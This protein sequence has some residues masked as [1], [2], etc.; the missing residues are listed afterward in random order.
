LEDIIEKLLGE[1]LRVNSKEHPVLIGE[2]AI[3]SREY[4]IK[5]AE[6]MFE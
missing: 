3:T 1:E 4:K 2:P 5:L 6:L